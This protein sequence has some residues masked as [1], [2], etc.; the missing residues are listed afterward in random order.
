MGQII[1]VFGTGQRDWGFLA[2]PC[3]SCPDNV[4]LGFQDAS[5]V[6]EPSTILLVGT[7]LSGLVFGRIRRKQK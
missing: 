1:G 5:T 3:P 7:G 2:T 4:F 6:P